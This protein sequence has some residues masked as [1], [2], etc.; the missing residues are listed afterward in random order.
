MCIMYILLTAKLI[1]ILTYICFCLFPPCRPEL[2]DP[3]S[4]GGRGEGFAVQA[5]VHPPD[6]QAVRVQG[7]AEAQPG[8]GAQDL[9]RQQYVHT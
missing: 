5:V 4:G 8:G 9:R 2:R 1:L 7:K 3:R 6:R